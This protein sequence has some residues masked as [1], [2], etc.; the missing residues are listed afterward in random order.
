[1][2]YGINYKDDSAAATKWLNRLHNLYLLST[3]DTDDTLNL[4][5]GVYGALETYLIDK[6]GIVY[7]KIVGMVDQK[8]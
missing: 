6:Q 5:L 7:R 3:S 4:D 2:I 1:M 8:V